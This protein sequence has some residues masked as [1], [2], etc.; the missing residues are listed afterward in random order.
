K[1]IRTTF[2]AAKAGRIRAV[3]ASASPAAVPPRNRRRSISLAFIAAALPCYVRFLTAFGGRRCGSDVPYGER[4]GPFFWKSGG[5]DRTE[6]HRGIGRRDQ[7][8]TNNLRFFA[9]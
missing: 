6:V 9:G 7:L 3:P 1:P 4:A 8:W 2:S 5:E